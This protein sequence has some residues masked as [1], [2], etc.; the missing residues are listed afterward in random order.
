MQRYQIGKFLGQGS[1]AVVK[2]A[3]DTQTGRLVALKRFEKYKLIESHVKKNLIREIRILESLDHPNVV[4]L[5]Q[6]I[7]QPRHINLVMEFIG[8]KTLAKFVKRS[9]DFRLGEDEAR[10]IFKQIVEGIQYCHEQGIV[11]RD[12]KLEN[13]IIDHELNIRIIDFGFAI[14]Y[15]P[16]KRLKI[17]CGTPEYLAPEVIANETYDGTAA[18]CWSLGVLLYIMLCGKKP[19]KGTAAA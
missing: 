8:V 6:V 16:S 13:I 2:L 18:D 1:Y 10:T 3:K 9:K 5:F 7:E 11:H 17:F 12:I 15:D 14:K 4:Q 19:F